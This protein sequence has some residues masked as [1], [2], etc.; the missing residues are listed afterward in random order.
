M[1]TLR[2]VAHES[3]TGPDPMVRRSKRLG[4]SKT[5]TRLRKTGAYMTKGKQTNVSRRLEYRRKTRRVLCCFLQFTSP[6]PV[7]ALQFIPMHDDLD[8]NEESGLFHAAQRSSSFVYA[9]TINSGMFECPWPTLAPCVD[10]VRAACHPASTL[11]IQSP[12]P[13][14]CSSHQ[15]ADDGNTSPRGQSVPRRQNRYPEQECNRS[16]PRN[17]D[18]QNRQQYPSSC[19]GKRFHRP[20]FIH[21]L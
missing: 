16:P 7:Q 11:Q 8:S 10:S 9:P 5:Q 3:L 2:K 13:Y 18:L 14:Y 21:I 6:S 4:P 15:T 20:V 17:A 12:L 19:T 1:V